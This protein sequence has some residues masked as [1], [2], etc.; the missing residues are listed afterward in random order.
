MVNRL[1][2]FFDFGIAR[3]CSNRAE[4]DI[5]LLET[6]ALRLGDEERECEHGADVNRGEHE[7]DLVPE[8]GNDVGRHSRDDE[9]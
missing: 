6:A 1:F 7:E 4:D 5:H 3:C 2:G 9:I 8:V